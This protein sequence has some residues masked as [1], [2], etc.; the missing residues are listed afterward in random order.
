MQISH[1]NGIPVCY[2]LLLLIIH[3]I[4]DKLLHT[5]H[6]IPLNIVHTIFKRD[7]DNVSINIDNDPISSK[8]THELCKHQVKNRQDICNAQ[9]IY[10]SGMLVPVRYTGGWGTVVPAADKVYC[11]AIA[12]MNDADRRTKGY[13]SSRF[14]NLLQLARGW[15]RHLSRYLLLW[16]YLTVPLY[17]YNYW[18]CICF[19]TCTV[20]WIL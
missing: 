1:T 9:C 5:S 14:Q 7:Q 20:S 8:P 12:I 15:I 4:L 6:R 2:Y 19:D 3:Y 11:L 17:I 10:A 13:D 18:L 16:T